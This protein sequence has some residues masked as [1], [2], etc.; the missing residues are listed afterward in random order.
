MKKFFM[1]FAISFIAVTLNAQW[2]VG[3]QLGLGIQNEREKTEGVKDLD[4]NNVYGSFLFGP[5]FGYSINDKW[6]VGLD[7]A[8]GTQFSIV[9]NSWS[10]DKIHFNRV[11]WEI[12]PF[13]KYSAFTYKNFSLLFK[14][15][16]GVGG[17]HEFA[18]IGK[19]KTVKGETTIIVNV[20]DIAP[21][22]D[23]KLT[24]HWHLDAQLDFLNLGYGIGIS[25]DDPDSKTKTTQHYFNCAFN[26]AN[27]LS[28]Q[29]LTIGAYYKF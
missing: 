21:I 19:E 28:V 13:A 14:G 25:K 1:I 23:F 16:I 7:V 9:E 22:L 15:S 4:R 17:V 10:T 3:G 5:Y 24:D 26:S 18:K 20:F 8:V 6:S 12:S 27:V 29:Y 11:I 2:F